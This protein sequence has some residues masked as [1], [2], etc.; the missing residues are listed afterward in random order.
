MP[1]ING[2]GAPINFPVDLTGNQGASPRVNVAES[3]FEYIRHPLVFPLV[4]AASI[5]PNLDVGNCFDLTL[6]ASTWTMAVPTFAGIAAN[7]DGRLF[8]FRIRQDGVGNRTLAWGVGYRFSSDLP[9][10]V[11]SPAPLALD[12]Y[13]FSYCNTDSVFDLI[14]ETKGF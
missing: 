8:M 7:Y 14:A 2:V 4:G 5:V 3:R 13:L 9:V 11:I 1:V 10:P 12:Y 6:T